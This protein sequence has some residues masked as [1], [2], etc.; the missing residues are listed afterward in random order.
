MYCVYN[1]YLIIF[2]KMFMLLIVNDNNDSRNSL[3]GGI[4]KFLNNSLKDTLF[5]AIIYN[6]L[7]L[8]YFS[9]IILTFDITVFNTTLFVSLYCSTTCL[10]HTW[11]SSGITAIVTKNVSL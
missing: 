2:L 4:L 9:H 5:A 8:V 11:P 1:L 6:F 3:A 10:G 7:L